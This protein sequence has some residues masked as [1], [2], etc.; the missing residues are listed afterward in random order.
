MT[1]YYNASQSDTTHTWTETEKEREDVIV[2]RWTYVEAKKMTEFRFF[3]SQK[4]GIFI[5]TLEI[6]INIIY[7]IG[8]II[9]LQIDCVLW[10]NV[11]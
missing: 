4:G 3:L 10:R 6:T 5:K 2:D 7:K 8:P 11:F 1:L 9:K